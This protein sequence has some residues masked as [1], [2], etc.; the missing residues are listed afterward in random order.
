MLNLSGK[1]E[2]KLKTRLLYA[3]GEESLKLRLRFVADLLSVPKHD[4]SDAMSLAL[5][6]RKKGVGRLL[7]NLF[8]DCLY[9]VARVRELPISH[10]AI[11]RA[12]AQTF[13]LGL[14]ARLSWLPDNRDLVCFMY[15]CTPEHLA[16]SL[17]G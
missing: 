11:K 5:A 9:V 16:E 7:H 13:D 10:S 1:A 15:D 6:L 2:A 14:R 17:Q 8:I 3:Q 4:T 12:T